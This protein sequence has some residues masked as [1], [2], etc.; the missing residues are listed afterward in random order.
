M[1]RL[2]T[3]SVAAIMGV[4]SFTPQLVHAYKTKKTNDISYLF[5]WCNIV[6]S[7][8]WTLYGYYDD[9]WVVIITDVLICLQ[10]FVLLLMKYH[11][12]KKNKL[13]TTVV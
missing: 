7:L 4:L 5:I 2:I 10:A 9:D 3:G 11:Y 6:M 12:D 13:N 1:E 8:V